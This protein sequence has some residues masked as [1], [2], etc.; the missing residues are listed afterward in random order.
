[1]KR[2]KGAAAIF[3]TATLALSLLALTGCLHRTVVMPEARAVRLYQ[4]QQ[5]PMSGWLLSESALAKILEAA[6]KCK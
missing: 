2:P 4:G 1:M 6:E 3:R 5:A